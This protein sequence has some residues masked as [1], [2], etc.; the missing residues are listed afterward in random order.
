MV[1]SSLLVAGSTSTVWPSRRNCKEQTAAESRAT[2]CSTFLHILVNTQ[3]RFSPPPAMNY[4][5]ETIPSQV[6]VSLDGQYHHLLYPYP[7][8]Q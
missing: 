5:E 2:P 7:Q 8:P 6:E 3:E 4:R 1:T